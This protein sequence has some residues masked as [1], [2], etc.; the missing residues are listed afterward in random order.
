MSVLHV[1]QGFAF[2]NPSEHVVV[3]S[4]RSFAFKD[5]LSRDEMAAIMV[6]VLISHSLT[7][8]QKY[9]SSIIN[10]ELNH[11]STINNFNDF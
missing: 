7:F 9:A 4:S 6:T 8:L 2:I 10:N 5:S 11:S 3:R 1:L